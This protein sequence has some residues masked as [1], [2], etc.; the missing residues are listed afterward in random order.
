MQVL[1]NDSANNSQF[2]FEKENVTCL[3]SGKCVLDEDT[4]VHTPLPS[5]L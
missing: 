1:D 2:L 3:F 5:L 4:L